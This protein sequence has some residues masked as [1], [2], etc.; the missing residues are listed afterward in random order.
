QGWGIA[1][2]LLGFE[3]IFLGSLAQ[4][5]KAFSRLADLAAKLGFADDPSFKDEFTR[6]A[7][8]VA[9]H[10]ALYEIYLDKVR[11]REELGPDVSMLKINQTE[12]YKRITQML[13][14][15]AGEHAGVMAEISEFG[16]SPSAVWVQSLPATIYGGASEV[17]RDIVS[18][19]LLRM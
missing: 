11:R 6:L 4:S 9:D 7:C 3:R 12:L 19:Q 15:I 17:Q 14:D 1:K 10:A 13:V 2:A 18:K 16:F 8:D 5:S